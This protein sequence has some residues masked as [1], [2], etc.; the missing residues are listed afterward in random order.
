M[1]NNTRTYSI[2]VYE[3]QHVHVK[4]VNIYT[5]QLYMIVYSIHV[6]CVYFKSC[7]RLYL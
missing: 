4:Y 3:V 5:V 6:I 1:Y 2:H 7:I